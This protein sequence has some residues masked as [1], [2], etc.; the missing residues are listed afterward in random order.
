MGLELMDWPALVMDV[1]VDFGTG[2]QILTRAGP[3]WDSV[4][5]SNIC[6]F[7]GHFAVMN[8]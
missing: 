6:Y 8:F 3:H 7:F 4:S 1:D 2:G 5:A